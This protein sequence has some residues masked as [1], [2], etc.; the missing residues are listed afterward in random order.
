MRNRGF[1]DL[2]PSV[3]VGRDVGMRW[4]PR[5]YRRLLSSL[6]FSSFPITL[7]KKKPFTVRLFLHFFKH[8]IIENHIGCV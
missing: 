3:M 1:D 8:T 5:C 6:L 2:A 4:P 7:L